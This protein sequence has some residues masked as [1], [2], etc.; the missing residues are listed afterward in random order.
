MSDCMFDV[1]PCDKRLI[2]CSWVCGKPHAESLQIGIVLRAGI[3]LWRDK[4]SGKSCICNCAVE[5]EKSSSSANT[6]EYDCP[7]DRMDS[8]GQRDQARH[9]CDY[10][11]EQAHAYQYS[12]A[13]D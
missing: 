13:D 3:F 9:A 10:Q 2:S 6:P 11:R 12:Q 1:F 7:S 8:V 4:C 5:R